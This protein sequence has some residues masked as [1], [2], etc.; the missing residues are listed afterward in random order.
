MYRSLASNL[1]VAM[2]S[3]EKW[4]GGWVGGGWGGG[5]H[6]GWPN[7]NR[8][9]QLSQTLTYGA[10]QLNFPTT[11]PTAVGGPP[12]LENLKG[13]QTQEAK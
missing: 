2:Q 12:R 3:G 10:A 6:T 8:L 11:S 9:L 4:V 13:N 1:L 7:T 5:T